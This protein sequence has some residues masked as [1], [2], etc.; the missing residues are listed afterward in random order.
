[1]KIKIMVGAIVVLCFA[2][3]I[4]IS[5]TELKSVGKVNIADFVQIFSED[6]SCLGREINNLMAE[7][8]KELN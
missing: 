6:I 2:T 4:N 7:C 5:A 3:G 8:G 1:M